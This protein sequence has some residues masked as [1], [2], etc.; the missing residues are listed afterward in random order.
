MTILEKAAEFGKA[1]ASAPHRQVSL[2]DLLAPTIL[3]GSKSEMDMTNRA[4]MY[5]PIV[6]G[7]MTNGTHCII[8][9]AKR[10]AMQQRL[11]NSTFGAL[12]IDCSLDLHRVSLG[13]ILL[14]KNRLKQPLE[15]VEVMRWLASVGDDSEATIAFLYGVSMREATELRAVLDCCDAVQMSVTSGMLPKT[16]CAE[17]SRMSKSDQESLIKLFEGMLPSLQLWRE[18]VEWLP[19]L[20]HV[21]GISVPELCNQEKMIA[22][23]NQKTL[24]SPQK[25]EKI[26]EIFFDLRF[27]TYSAAR[28]NWRELVHKTS[29][30]ATRVAFKET[31]GFEKQRLEVKLTLKNPDEALR[32]CQGLSAISREI[33]KKLISPI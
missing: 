8:D 17:I 2:A 31:P 30:D 10:S 1:L 24:N 19:E 23:Q 12:I 21:Y 22:L 4:E 9:G 28:K 15:S 27:P 14:N 6:V 29:P 32:I 11:G 3:D 25:L 7:V 13:R 20:A 5:L 16:M 26:R 18:I 33:W